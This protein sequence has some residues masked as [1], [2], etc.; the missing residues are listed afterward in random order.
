MR[1]VRRQK[2]RDQID[3]LRQAIAELETQQ[4]ELGLDFTQQ[5]AELQRRL[6]DMGVL[7]QHGPGAV[8]ATGGVAAGAGGVAVGGDNDRGQNMTV[9]LMAEAKEKLEALLEEACREGEILIKR[10]DGQIFVIRPEQRNRSPLDV[11]G[12]NLGLSK[13]EIAQSVREGRERS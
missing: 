10:E 7:V 12:V 8:A 13:S 4:R 1:P 9:Y 3:K 2:S 5:I 6:R 11:P